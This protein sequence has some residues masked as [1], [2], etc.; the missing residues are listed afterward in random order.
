MLETKGIKNTN[1]VIKHDLRIIVS[2]LN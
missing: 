1:T 2:M